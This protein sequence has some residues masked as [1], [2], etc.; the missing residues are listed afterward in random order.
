MKTYRYDGISRKGEPVQGLADGETVAEVVAGGQ[1]I[2]HNYYTVRELSDGAARRREGRP[3]SAA[4]LNLFTS[5]LASLTRSGVPLA[6]ALT[7]LSRDLGRGR[8]GRV[9]ENLASDVA[10]GESLEEAL[11]AEG[12]A[13]PPL[14]ISLVRV[15]ERTGNL[16]GVLQQLSQ[17]AQ[18]H[19]WLRYRLQVAMA[20]PL[21][22]AVV[23]T[24]FMGVFV[25]HVMGQFAE[26]YSSFGKELPE[27]SQA[28]LQVG[29]W[30]LPLG[31]PLLATIACVAVVLRLL[32]G[33]GRLRR[34]IDHLALR[35]PY[36]GPVIYTVVA[37]RFFRALSLLLAHGAPIV[38]SLH[39]AGL[40]SGNA[41][42]EQKIG[43]AAGRIAQGEGVSDAVRETGLLRRSHGWMLQQGERNGKFTE[44]LGSLADSCDTEAQ[45]LEKSGLA[46][47]GPAAVTVCGVLVGIAVIACFLPVF[48]MGG[49]IR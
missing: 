14:Y 42:F 24:L 40:A 5:Q 22:L 4:D 49:V 25:P 13:V 8:L 11:R 37:A 7:E 36:L 9:L 39:L 10:G 43:R 2:D 35:V 19:L 26:I 32:R 44:T 18:R 15:G 48:Q 38:E 21:I 46:L 12:D 28:V 31:L 16:P 30:V 17:F 6:P 23:L 34:P 20:Y 45:R 33:W 29:Y 27:L 1:A 47:L 3:L 41:V